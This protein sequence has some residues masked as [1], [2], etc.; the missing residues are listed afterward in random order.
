MSSDMV[1]S[2]FRDLAPQRKVTFDAELMDGQAAL[3]EANPKRKTNPET[4]M[5]VKAVPGS[6]F[7]SP[8]RT[9]FATEQQEAIEK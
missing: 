2:Q 7:S 1:R 4:A 3:F 8:F 6:T 9:V 5:K